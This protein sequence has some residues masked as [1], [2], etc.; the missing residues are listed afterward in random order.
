VG[1]GTP[2]E[3]GGAQLIAGDHVVL[4]AGNPGDR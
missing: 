4:P 1:D 2:A 3:A